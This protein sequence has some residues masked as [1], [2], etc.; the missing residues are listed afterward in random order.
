MEEAKAIAWTT[1]QNPEGHI[2]SLTC[3]DGGKIEETYLNLATF[4]ADHP[5]LKPFQQ[6]RNQ[7]QGVVEEAQDLGGVIVADDDLGL[8]DF[9]PKAGDRVAGQT[10]ELQADE[11][12]NDGGKLQFWKA[13]YEYPLHTHY[14][15]EYGKGQ[16]A[17]MFT[18]DWEKYFPIVSGR[19]PTPSGSLIIRLL[20]SDKKNN[21]GNFYVNLVNQRRP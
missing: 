14:L 21:K 19:T 1:V 12:T 8:I 2:I 6:Y 16:L 9:P 7:Y 15:N 4:L 5:H 13:G 11:F 17:E 3:R 10:F 20:V 18:D